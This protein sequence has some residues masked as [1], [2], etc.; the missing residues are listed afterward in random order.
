MIKVLVETIYK[1]PLIVVVFLQKCPCYIITE[2]TENRC[3]F[4]MFVMKQYK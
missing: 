1:F 3:S 2:N 4:S